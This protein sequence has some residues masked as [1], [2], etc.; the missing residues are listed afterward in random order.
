MTDAV[1]SECGKCALEES[2]A[3]TRPRAFP[4]SDRHHQ[5]GQ[6]DRHGGLLLRHFRNR[7]RNSEDGAI[8]RFSGPFRHGDKF[9]D[10]MSGPRR[11][12][13]PGQ[14][15]GNLGVHGRCFVVRMPDMAVSASS[16]N[17]AEVTLSPTINRRYISGPN[18]KSRTV[19]GSTGTRSS[20]P[21]A[22]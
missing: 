8:L 19:S 16:R 9:F 5:P 17:P 2:T 3:P 11:E 13:A 18:S 6:S 20:E 7:S 21:S 22:R 1:P 10:V 4:G 12:Q 15:S 14:P